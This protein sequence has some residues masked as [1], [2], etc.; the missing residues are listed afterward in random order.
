M[1]GNSEFERRNASRGRPSNKVN[2][3]Q[4]MTNKFY[5]HTAVNAT[6]RSLLSASVQPIVMASSTPNTPS[7]QQQ[8]T[9]TMPSGT[10]VS[11]YKEIIQ[12]LKP[13]IMKDSANKRDN[14]RNTL[15]SSSLLSESYATAGT[16]NMNRTYM[17]Q[18]TSDLGHTPGINDTTS[19]ID[20]MAQS[21]KISSNAKMPQTDLLLVNNGQTASIVG[22]SR[23]KLSMYK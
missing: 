11:H 5:A 1:E 12:S 4:T 22:P 15:N 14:L 13:H 19:I 18:V 9:A 8:A 23:F 2:L 16:T 6:D 20:E 7:V 10:R 3:S 17:S 21:P